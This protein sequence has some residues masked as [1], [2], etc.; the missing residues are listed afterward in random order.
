MSHNVKRIT[1]LNVSQIPIVLILLKNKILRNYV[2]NM[3]NKVK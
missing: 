3:F 1:N 2:I